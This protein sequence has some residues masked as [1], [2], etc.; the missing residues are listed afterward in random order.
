MAVAQSVSNSSNERQSGPCPPLGNSGSAGSSAGCSDS[1]GS[2]G[3]GGNRDSSVFGSSSRSSSSSS[4]SSSSTASPADGEARSVRRT[5]RLGQCIKQVFALFAILL[6][7]LRFLS[8]VPAAWGGDDAR[9]SV[10]HRGGAGADRQGGFAI[11]PLAAGRTSACP[12]SLSDYSRRQLCCA[13]GIRS[14]FRPSPK[15]FASTA[16]K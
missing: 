11:L 8:A 15:P 1:G 16:A 9:A 7:R 14:L 2:G 12:P 13:G 10:S 4:S 3:G 5:H 6:E